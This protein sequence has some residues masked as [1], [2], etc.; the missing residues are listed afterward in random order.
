MKG[1][2]MVKNETLR[3]VVANVQYIAKTGRQVS[4]T[5]DPK[6]AT[7]LTFEVDG[8]FLSA[9]SDGFPALSEGDEVEVTGVPSRAGMEVVQLQNHTT[10]AEWQFNPRAAAKRSFFR[11]G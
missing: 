9:M 7:T 1:A 11:G 2:T 8:R 10:G 4:Y 5:D 6:K 3:G